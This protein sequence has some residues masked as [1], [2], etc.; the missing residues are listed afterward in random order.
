MPSTSCTRVYFQGWTD[1]LSTNTMYSVPR[2]NDQV[3][4]FQPI[5]FNDYWTM[6]HTITDKTNNPVPAQVKCVNYYSVMPNNPRPCNRMGSKT[7]TEG[8]RTCFQSRCERCIDSFQDGCH[9]I[10]SSRYWSI[11]NTN[12][13][14]EIQPDD[15]VDAYTDIVVKY[16]I[17]WLS[18]PCGKDGCRCR[19]SLF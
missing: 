16:H 11:D 6:P 5:N 12:T 9:F 14:V 17:Q 2:M 7:L 4:T 15:R 8:I 19:T 3:V 1:I 10:W 13:Q 18:W